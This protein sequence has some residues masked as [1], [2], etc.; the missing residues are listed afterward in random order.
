MRGYRD[1]RL[2]EAGRLVDTGRESYASLPRNGGRSRERAARGEAGA[3][4]AS[5]FGPSQSI[6]GFLPKVLLRFRRAYPDVLLQLGDMPTPD[7]V[8][9]LVN[10]SIETGF[11]ATPCTGRSPGGV[12]PVLNEH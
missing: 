9:A 8:N 4:C 6:L 12:R 10:R 1:V 5:A 2:T 7:Q 11:R 3:G